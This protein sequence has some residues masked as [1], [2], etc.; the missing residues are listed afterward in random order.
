MS[1]MTTSE[2]TT[3]QVALRIRPLTAE[4][5]VNLP[6]RFQRN[7]LN[8]TLFAPNQVTV[9]QGEKKQTFTFDHVFGPDSSQKDIYD[10]CIKSMVDKFLEGFNV[11]ILAY[12]QTSS[13]K[14]HTMG[15]ADNLTSPQESRGII[16]RSMATLFSY[17][18]SAQYKNRK[19]TM[20]VSFV[21]IYN[22]DLID[23]LAEGDDECKPQVLIR[24]DSKGNIIWSGLQE[25]K[26]VSAT[27]MNAQSSRSHAIFSVTLSQQKF[28]PSGGG[29]G[30][31]SPTPISRPS[32]PSKFSSS[33]SR[34]GSRMGKRTDDGD[35]V[36]V[37]SKF[38]FVDL[39]GS[40]RLK[41]T[42][43]IGDRAKEGISINSG[44]LALGN[45]ISA[46]GDPTKAKSATHIPYRDSKLTRLLQDSLGGNAQTIM[47]ACVSPAEYN[48]SETVNT[49]KYANR[50]RNIKNV[51]TVTQEEAGW[52]DL[53]HLQHLVIKL[54]N[55]IKNL[56]L[57]TG[58]TPGSGRSTPSD[59]INFNHRRS[60]TSSFNIE[61]LEEQLADLQRSYSELTQKYAKISAELSSYQDN[62][63]SDSLKSNSR[64]LNAIMEDSDDSEFLS[65]A[66]ASFQ[67]TVAPV[68]A[69]YEKSINELESQLKI[70]RASLSST[71]KLMQDQELKLEEAEDLNS[72]NKSLITDLKNKI[73]KLNERE[74]TTETYIKDL[75]SKLDSYS[76]EQKKDQDTINDLRNKI[77]QLRI[78]GENNEGIIQKLETRLARSESKAEL[79]NETAQHLEKALMEREDAYN[80]LDLK[81]KNEKA[82]DEQQQILL[83]AEIEDRDR[84]ISQLEKK[85]DD[86][87]AE[88][89]QFKKLKVDVNKAPR[90]DYSIVLNLESKLYELQ[91]THE[92]TVSEF[93]EIKDKYQACLGEIED[94]QSQL[95]DS[96]ILHFEVIDTD[97]S[98]S[99]PTTNKQSDNVYD[100]NSLSPQVA[101]SHRK[102]RSLSAEI[103]GAEKRELSSLAM[104]QKLQIEL[105][106]LESLHKDKAEGLEAVKKEFARLEVNHLE[107]LEIVEE[108]REEIK[109]RDALAQIEVMSVMTSEYAY[110]ESGYS[111][112][113][114]EIDQLEIVNRLREE[115]E[116]L[117]EEQRKNLEIIAKNENDKVKD[118]SDLITK[119]ETNITELKTELKRMIDENGNEN[120]IQSL[121]SKI[122]ELEDQQESQ[123]QININ[124]AAAR[125]EGV[126]AR[127]EN[128]EILDL[129]QQVDKLQG[130]IESKKQLIKAKEGSNIPNPRD[131]IINSADPTYRAVGGLEQKLTKLRQ[132][133]ALKSETSKEQEIVVALQEQVETLKL[134]IHHKYELIEILKR[135]LIDKTNLQQRLKEKEAEALIFRSKLM[136]VHKQETELENEI[137]RL[138]SRL[139]KLE[140]GEDVN[141]V[142]QTE[143]ETLRKE[144]KDVR[145]REA[146][147]LDRL[148]V[149][150]ARLGSDQE[151]THLQEQLEH[152]RVVE[153]AQRERITILEGRL[154]EQ[155]GQIDEDFVK[156]KTELALARES[157]SAQKRTIENLEIKLKKAEDRSQLSTLRREITA[158]KAKEAEQ[159]KKIRDLEFQLNESVNKDSYQVK[160][161]K[162]E[163]ENLNANK[164]EQHK[165]IEILES[166]LEN[167]KEEDPNISAL[168][169]QIAGLKASEADL[170]R[171]V[172][173]LESKYISAQ[174]EIKVFETVKEEVAFLKELESE[175]KTTIEQL[176]TQLRKIR[177]SKE[178]AIKELQSMKGGF[179]LQKELVVSL[180]EELKVLRQDLAFA[181]ENTDS[182]S[183]EL[184]KIK[185]L[186]NNTQTHRDDAQRRVKALEIEVETYK[187]AGEAGN[188][189]IGKLREELSNVKLEM[190]AQNEM[191]VE[192]EAQMI[193]IE[194]ERDENAKRVDELTTILKERESNQKDA[195]KELESTL[196]NLETEL[197]MAKDSSKINKETISN[198][199]EKL[200][201]VR[202]QL[203]EAK[204]S[205][206]K[207]T[208]VIK[209]LEVKF[210]EATGNLLEKENNLGNQ[211]KLVAELETLI[212]NTQNELQSVKVSETEATGRIKLLEA[213]LAEA[214]KMQINTFA[215]EL[216]ASE[217]ELNKVRSYEAKHA[218]HIK[219]LESKLQ[220]VQEH[221]QQEIS[222]L[223]QA[224]EEISLLREKCAQLQEEI[225][226]AH[227]DSVIKSYENIDNNIVEDLNNQLKKALN[228]VQEQQDR[229]IELEKAT[230][231]LESEKR[232]QCE[233]NEDLE[234]QVEQLQKDLETLAEEFAE[235]ASKFE[236]ADELSRQQKTRIAELENALW[237]AKKNYSE[238]IANGFNESEHTN[239]SLVKLAAAN[240]QLR[241]TNESLN[242][243]I[244]EAEE[245]TQ[246][247]TDKAKFLESEL[248]R[249]GS[250][251]QESI[252]VLKNKIKELEMEKNG[253]E[254]A[255]EALFDERG[256]LDQKIE[257]LM[258]Q[259]RSVNNGDIKTSAQVAELNE[260]IVNLEREIVDLRKQTLADTKEMEKEITRLLDINDQLEKDIK[261]N[262]RSSKDIKVIIP[263]SDDDNISSNEQSKLSHQEATIAQQNNVIKSLQDKI[264]ELEESRKL[265]Q[266]ANSEARFSRSTFPPKPDSESSRHR[267]DSSTSSELAIEI[268]KLQK[269][270]TKMENENLQNNQLVETLESSLNE[271]ETN[272]RVAKQQLTILQREK[273]EFLEQIKNL[274]AQ[275][276]DAQQQVEQAK[277][278]VREEKKAMESVLEEERKAKEKAEKARIAIESQMEK[279]VAKR[280]KFMCF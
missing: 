179:S 98:I 3:V 151:E 82:Q 209:E 152:L 29:G 245:Q 258:Q 227:R 79:M 33:P 180:E 219:S 18:N 145:A 56:R 185:E 85:V 174:K 122:K 191:I 30:P 117:K 32:T 101:G 161:L 19:F 111:A 205:D 197:V 247:L 182:S 169:D 162:E 196:T 173:D 36:S 228:Q 177:N 114:S 88:I 76:S 93:A 254:E 199:E 198:L 141:K 118:K 210:K 189:N 215:A 17:I 155:G 147:T 168:R 77:S 43:A 148:H 80:K 68:I 226:S 99:S 10:R 74:E 53:E 61:A 270:I 144:L 83:L 11:T 259:L 50:A 55:E 218:Q 46:L 181:K 73:L 257:F 231:Q 4:D 132:E 109:R 200:S 159:I 97:E 100:P 188:E 249:L 221:H 12:G 271:N 255:N 108:L 156:L 279:L 280:N 267:S 69:E 153:I 171:T 193:I 107:T 234:D 135:D 190:S 129:R 214:T 142:L 278:T 113:T 78:N 236:D 63:N 75:E 70:A 128:A 14:T 266:E 268:Q 264:S 248:T 106:Q 166:R 206:E 119:I 121:Q 42:S 149:L 67:E 86:L 27:D 102:S 246:V 60:S 275:L 134:D 232:I 163:I 91:K 54:R 170:Q 274:R 131:S 176:Q 52:H 175:Q 49:L 253:L 164:Q 202:L 105:K 41:R 20:K 9:L 252:K 126:P 223:K 204:D 16:P 28:I 213:K 65:H 115:V 187:L 92:K 256:K 51:A 40:E 186:L 233:R 235:A 239:P 230:K 251:D 207:R 2:N 136:D 154:S 157:E 96:K 48:V 172:Q 15:T 276:D 212:Q 38:H 124:E 21:E 217:A 58:L 143:L 23:L 39:A 272:L 25:I 120:M 178:T 273:Q 150:K 167:I 160:L 24:E 241:Q 7:V 229:V 133:L 269:K 203:K 184:E 8:T 87:I 66:T 225:G 62:N 216:E 243:K 89:A 94:L 130:E 138:K 277:S 183:E 110:T 71:E 250:S 22:E 237:E 265:L 222:K 13:G 208:N 57:S 240:E 123:R 34:A 140:N 125:L 35:W 263:V 37:S 165:Q 103:Q 47:I 95:Q 31:V 116:Q 90:R 194:K 104:I 224:E 262:P 44:L 158:L 84:R 72:K 201:I 6:T 137:N 244:V 112:A 238:D 5:L 1:N 220:E 59:V 139:D 211:D 146:V 192:L 64:H 261:M 127:D 260:Q 195:I 242:G 81:Y 45:V 26:V